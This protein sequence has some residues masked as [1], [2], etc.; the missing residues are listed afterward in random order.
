MLNH[1]LRPGE[2]LSRPNFVWREARFQFRAFSSIPSACAQI[3]AKGSARVLYRRV[4]FNGLDSFPKPSYLATVL[5][6][7]RLPEAAAYS[8]IFPF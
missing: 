7:R 4:R 1:V 8:R 5:R 2:L 6:L 3:S